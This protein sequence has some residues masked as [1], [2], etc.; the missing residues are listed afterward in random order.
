MIS[1]KHMHVTMVASF[2]L[3]T[4]L[5]VVWCSD[6]FASEKSKA[7]I[8]QVVLPGADRF[9]KPLLKRLRYKYQTLGK[10]YK[11]RTRHLNK[12]GSPLYTNR[13]FL[14]SSP[15]LLQH[16][17]NPVNWFPWGDEAFALAKKLNR[18]VLLSIGYST[19]HWCHVMEE[20]SFED[21]E[22]A[23]IL[24]QKYIAIKVDRE[25]RPD[26]DAIYMSAVQAM[27]GRGG[28]PLNVWLTT[29]R[30]PFFGGTYFPPRDGDRGVQRGFLTIVSELSNIYHQK[31]IAVNKTSKQLTDYVQ[32]QLAPAVSGSL[33]GAGVIRAVAQQLSTRF[34]PEYGGLQGAPKFPS[35]YPIRLMLR[36]HRRSGDA[37]ALNDS[38]HT[39]N[40]MADGGMHDHVGGG[41]HRYSTDARWLEPH[42]EKMLYDNALLA[43]AYLEAYQLTGDERFKRINKKILRY[44]ARDMTSPEGAFYSATD[45]D[46]PT[47]SGHREEGW[48]FTWTPAEVNAILDADSARLLRSYYQLS[49][50]G[51]FEGRNIL[52]SPQSLLEV[53]R[54]FKRP[55]A[56]VQQQLDA[57]LEKLYNKRLQRPPPIRDNKILT[58]WNGLMI[59]AYARAGFV[60]N[61]PDYRDIAKKSASF[62]LNNL[63]KEGRLYR[64][65][66]NGE[67]HIGAFLD[68]YAFFIAALLDLYEVTYDIEWLQH[69]IEL[70]RTLSVLYEDKE[71]GGFFMT[72]HDHEKLLA[73]EKPSYDGAEPSGNSVAI[74]NLLRL[75]QFTTDDTYRLRA[76]KALQAFSGV[77]KNNSVALAEMLLAVDF[78]L[79]IPKQIIIVT[80]PGERTKAEP[81][82]QQLR[83]IFL[84]NRILS[85]VEEGV[86][87][88]RQVKDIP[89]L[90]GKR[91][92]QGKATA[93]VC[94]QGRCKQPTV[95]VALFIKQVTVVEPL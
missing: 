75:Q 18:P 69:A 28:W 56:T 11:P 17:H 73:R 88:K 42:F 79:D 86:D 6:S 33:V 55:V 71:Q 41:F 47:P 58:A 45:A 90:K 60:L 21:P 22:I 74:L 50:S 5:I 19:C 13:L 3:I 1:K 26:I 82:L 77:L 53:A 31:F 76:E 38:R 40:K 84:P 80:P 59:S 95:D 64:R 93:Y 46:S 35:S 51:N 89:L 68:D 25:E 83:Q 7:V 43:V 9:D 49:D 57:S 15:Y 70:D 34:D 32:Q 29:E 27:T 92:L 4:S 30:N 91:A 39:L 2:L 37:Q 48:F 52:H 20:E 16:A 85:V 44:I 12:K 63:Y 54:K 61:E 65:Y 10:T 66:I 87:L 94:E 67:R 62:V 78:H 24:N 8:A 81:F 14:E 72:S 36:Y 23:R